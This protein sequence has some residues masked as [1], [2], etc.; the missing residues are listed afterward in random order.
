MKA[1]FF[2]ILALVTFACTSLPSVE[3]DRMRF[4]HLIED[5]V[6]KTEMVKNR[7]CDEFSVYVYYFCYGK[8]AGLLEAQRMFEDSVY[9]APTAEE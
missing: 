7:F 2:S 5:E 3:V 8:I 4:T 9:L 1:T 6:W